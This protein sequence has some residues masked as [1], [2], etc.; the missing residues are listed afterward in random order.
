MSALAIES[1]RMASS[2]IGKLRE[3]MKDRDRIESRRRDS[4]REKVS[5]L[6][7]AERE[8]G[9]ERRAVEGRVARDITV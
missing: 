8:L 2:L 6:T 1:V 5:Q 4:N 3:G 9:P 7:Q